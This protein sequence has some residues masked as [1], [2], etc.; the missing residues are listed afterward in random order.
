LYTHKGK[1]LKPLLKIIGGKQKS[2]DRL[3]AIYPE[4]CDT[5]VEPFLGSGSVLIGGPVFKKEYANDICFALINF[6][7]KVQENPH[8]LY[9]SI[10]PEL[11]KL[12]AGGKDYFYSLRNEEPKYKQSLDSYAIWT[13]LINKS[14]F[15][16]I[17]RWSEKKGLCN[18]SYA[19]VKGRGWLTESWIKTVS[20]R[21]EHVKF[22]D[23]DFADLLVNF[24]DD[25]KTFVFLDPPYF[26]KGKEDPK[27]T[28]TVY[29]GKR[30]TTEDHEIL[31]S[32]L[33][34]AKFKW[35]MTIN[36]C[37]WTREVY[38]DF[39][40]YDNLINY[41]CS[42]TNA[43]RGPKNELVISNYPVKL[44]W[45]SYKEHLNADKESKSKNKK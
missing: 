21:I 23:I 28:V 14:C 13:Y 39:E 42:Q 40:I 38:K 37:E 2:R 27:G 19:A 33:K 45:E 9:H 18:S 26:L 6:Y 43:G 4:D 10:K 30:F 35:L 3:Y 8:K 36:D 31:A 32:I 5:F 22:T 1:I 29:N 17:L 7:R 34:L 16:G 15:N 41:S 11:D 25:S 44:K 20:K 24:V 12:V